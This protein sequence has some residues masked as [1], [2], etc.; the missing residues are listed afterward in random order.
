M[1]SMPMKSATNRHII[2][3][4]LSAVILAIVTVLFLRFY[5]V[6]V[7]ECTFIPIGD[8]AG[9]D[10]PSGEPLFSAAHDV[11]EDGIKVV[12]H[13]TVDSIGVGTTEYRTA[14]GWTNPVGTAPFWIGGAPG[15]VDLGYGNVV[16]DILAE[17]VAGAISENGAVVVG[18]ATEDNIERPCRWIAETLAKLPPVDGD[19]SGYATDT[20]VDG[21]IIVGYTSPVPDSKPEKSPR[22]PVRWD[23]FGGTYNWTSLPL[24]TLDVPCNSGEATGVDDTGELVVGS[25]ADTTLGRFTAVWPAIWWRVVP[26]ADFKLKILRGVNGEL[27]KGQVTAISGDGDFAVG[28]IGVWPDQQACW[29][30]VNALQFSTPSANLIPFLPGDVN[31][32]STCTSRFGLRIYGTH[33]FL[34]TIPEPDV[35]LV[36]SFVFE[37]ISGKIQDLRAFMDATEGGPPPAGWD[38]SQIMGVSADDMTLVGAGWNGTWAEGWVYRCERVKK[39][40]ILRLRTWRPHPETPAPPPIDPLGDR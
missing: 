18:K 40:R 29:W 22:H 37:R 27:V 4:L 9:G 24:D 6:E 28:S 30:G 2:F 12:G 11:S 32:A 8:F 39:T 20:N 38:I 21:K 17:S 16:G 1:S 14:A 15:L 7:T 36:K 35:E 31:S 5:E 25:V 19:T 34:D 3:G 10:Y 23:L 33:T 26:Q 13:G